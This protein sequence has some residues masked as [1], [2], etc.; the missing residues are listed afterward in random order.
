MVARKP[1]KAKAK[2][3]RGALE[4]KLIAAMFA[5]AEEGQWSE[6]TL[7]AIARKAKVKSAAIPPRL[8]DR[9]DVVLIWAE[10]LAAGFQAQG[11]GDSAP[12]QDRVF[13]GV[14]EVLEAMAPARAGLAAITASVM[15]QP[16]Q[17]VELLM[18]LSHLGRA[19]ARRAGLDAASLTGQAAGLGL[20]LLIARLM[21]V[22]A[23]D[24]PGLGKTMAL[25][26]RNLSTALSLLSLVP[27]VFG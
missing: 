5:L 20:A 21:P 11:H 1:V 3:A 6:L 24:E 2:P 22:F 18:P 7:D 8:R 15:R 27:R 23:E 4:N 12:L 9:G 10:K 19:A 16:V 26:D 13:D 17:A 25:L 14:M